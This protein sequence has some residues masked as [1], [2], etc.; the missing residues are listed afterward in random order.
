MTEIQL[1]K[2]NCIKTIDS[3]SKLDKSTLQKRIASYYPLRGSIENLVVN[4]ANLLSNI[5]N[6][7]YKNYNGNTGLYFEGQQ[8]FIIPKNDFSN[9]YGQTVSFW[10]IIDLNPLQTNPDLSIC[11]FWSGVL[12]NQKSALYESWTI[13]IEISTMDCRRFATWLLYSFDEYRSQLCKDRWSVSCSINDVCKFLNAQSCMSMEKKIVSR[14]K[15]EQ[16][17]RTDL[18]VIIGGA[19][20]PLRRPADKRYTW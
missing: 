16:P 4:N 5:R 9:L 19:P 12:S 15:W 2:G 6:L 13:H 20:P 14:Y 10:I 11:L 8:Y 7:K 17:K 1:S 18:S 3:I